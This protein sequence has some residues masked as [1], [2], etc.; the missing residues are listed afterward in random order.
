MA[1]TKKP[2]SSIVRLTHFEIQTSLPLEMVLKR[3]VINEAHYLSLRGRP[4]L[5]PVKVIPR[6]E[7][8]VVEVE[9][10][11]LSEYAALAEVG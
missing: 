5:G 1:R 10:R 11:P 3:T 9:Q 2:E 7:P 6:F 8:G 4:H